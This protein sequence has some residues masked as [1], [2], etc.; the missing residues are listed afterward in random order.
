MHLL[1]IKRL[2]FSENTFKFKD[3][4]SFYANLIQT[5]KTA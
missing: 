4:Y 1:D 5:T 2:L 3:G